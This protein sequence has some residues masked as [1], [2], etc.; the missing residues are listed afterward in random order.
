MSNKFTLR[1]LVL[2]YAVINGRDVDWKKFDEIMKGLSLGSRVKGEKN[3]HK[4]NTY[5]HK[6]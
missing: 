6:R 4:I 5:T 1:E 3:E 2:L